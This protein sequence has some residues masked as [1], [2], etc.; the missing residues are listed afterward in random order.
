MAD[1]EK[2]LREILN[3]IK[4]SDAVNLFEEVAVKNAE[5][6][7]GVS[8]FIK[9]IDTKRMA[10]DLT[11][12]LAAVMSGI[13][14]ITDKFVDYSKD[15][16]KQRKQFSEEWIHPEGPEPTYSVKKQQPK[17]DLSHTSLPKFLFSKGVEG[18]KD[19]AK[20]AF[21]I[22]GVG[23][24]N[25]YLE[26]R[27]KE[28]EEAEKLQ[29]KAENVKVPKIKKLTKAEQRVKDDQDLAKL[30]EEKAKGIAD[31]IKRDVERFGPAGLS[32]SSSSYNP[33][34]AI[35]KAPAFNL[36]EYRASKE[37]QTLTTKSSSV[38]VGVSKS[39][40]DLYQDPI[41][42][43]FV[44]A[45]KE[46]P[47]ATKVDLFDSKTGKYSY[48][49]STSAKPWLF[50]KK[51]D[52][53]GLTKASAGVGKVVKGLETGLTGLAPAMRTAAVGVTGLSA[54]I[55]TMGA[56][57]LPI[58]LTIVGVGAALLVVGKLFTR[59]KKTD[60]LKLDP[61]KV[62]SDTKAGVVIPDIEKK[63]LEQTQKDKQEA[64][65]YR[66]KEVERTI[67]HNPSPTSSTLVIGNERDRVPD[68]ASLTALQFKGAGVTP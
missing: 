50:S 48:K 34:K 57:I 3:E 42:H 26:L 8:T 14:T 29:E 11:N 55:A 51:P 37:H 27:K 25:E 9:K 59:D 60:E 20:E 7:K 54:G 18:I 65:E 22:P 17:S 33:S 46:E 66:R 58:L 67:K 43:K 15:L 16:T 32:E 4:V 21:P 19:F 62:K 47:K 38:K 31:G 24:I 44:K 36:D 61:E 2:T 30:S 39:G 6:I 52:T 10:N 53:T 56:T 49:D 68:P 23:L 5:A 12:S 1:K 28:K 45:P 35:N 40:R 13:A 63:K 64:A 41:T